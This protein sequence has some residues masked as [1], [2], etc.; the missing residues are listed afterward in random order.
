MST[1]IE[2][3]AA[4]TFYLDPHNGS[5]KHS[6]SRSEPWPSLQAVLEA[7]LVSAQK[8]STPYAAHSSRVNVNPD[9]PVK[10]GDTLVLMSGY[11]GEIKIHSLLNQDFIHVKAAEGATAT[12]SQISIRASSYWRIEGLIVSASFLKVA[13]SWRTMIDVENHAH[14]G[15]SA[16]I[17]LIDN[18]VYTYPDI[19]HWTRE[20]WINRSKNGIALNAPHSLAKGNT[21]YNTGNA[22]QA[23]ADYIT[24]SDNRI[25][26]FSVDGLR[27]LGDNST[28]TNNLIANGFKVDE[29]HDDAFQS[30]SRDGKPVKNVVLEGNQIYWDYY[31]PNKALRSDFQGIGCF[32]G[33]YENWK[34]RNNLLVVNHWHGITLLGAKNS[35]IV[36]NT[37]VDADDDISK[38][39]RIQIGDR[40]NGTLSTDNLIR[41]NLSVIKSD[42]AGVVADHN[43]S[44]RDR[45][46]HFVDH[47]NLNFE[48]AKNSPARAA[49]LNVGVPP[50]DI[51][52]RKRSAQ[53][54]IG[55]FQSKLKP[56]APHN[57]TI[58]IMELDD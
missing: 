28:Y 42:S 6:G 49:G 15:P 31:H 52:G 1:V 51:D 17:Q 3:A 12:A 25:V 10:S 30:W 13:P 27:G 57:L 54:D 53:V 33:I 43:Q 21:V 5:L 55:A 2:T 36:N 11:H 20:D 50:T 16:H 24:V 58:T 29:N 18:T 46:I 56:A 34:I 26:N 23:L 40:K 32:D 44:S 35:E 4:A 45:D 19:A 48:L 38:A 22:V 14:H 9:A 41:N 39:P 7:G 47:K 8:W 37:V